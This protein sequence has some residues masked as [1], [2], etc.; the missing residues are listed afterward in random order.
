MRLYTPE[1]LADIRRN[2]KNGEKKFNIG[3]YK[4]IFTNS[5]SGYQIQRIPNFA[6]GLAYFPGSDTFAVN[7]PHINNV[8]RI[9][10]E[11][12]SKGWVQ[13][14]LNGTNLAFV[15]ADGRIFHR[16]RGTLEPEKVINDINTAVIQGKKTIIGIPEQ[17]FQSF[18]TR[19]EATLRQGIG[20]GWV[21]EYGNVRIKKMAGEII[22]QVRWV[23]D[24]KGVIG[25]FGELCSRY[26]PIS[27]DQTITAGI[28]I[29]M[30]EPYNYVVFDIVTQNDDG[31]VEFWD[32]GAIESLSGAFPSSE[33][34]IALVKSVPLSIQV[35]DSALKTTKE[36]GFVVKSSNGYF[37]FKREDVL[38]WERTVGYLPNVLSFSVSHI[39][40]QEFSYSEAEV[41]AGALKKPTLRQE[42][43]DAA[44]SEAENNGI[45]RPQLVSFYATLGGGKPQQE[46]ERIVD[47]NL[48]DMITEKLLLFVAPALKNN[49]VKINEVWKEVPKYLYFSREP[50]YFDQKK[51]RDRANGWYSKL[52]GGI[53][54]RTYLEPKK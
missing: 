15:R 44:W 5:S 19:Y 37:K 3:A 43:I 14:K 27:V 25:V 23:L 35:L 32:V 24:T 45:T 17:T 18:K 47:H 21:D 51:Q 1:Q 36:E 49:G 8:R 4:C 42:I 54:G 16:T 2:L 38:Q 26:N 46:A 13:P 34:R 22:P 39:F 9:E 40:E 20:E 31:S 41:M 11:T 12:V 50:I 6:L 48:E 53:I 30:P 29:D 28:Y 52:I 7:Y 10:L 33:K